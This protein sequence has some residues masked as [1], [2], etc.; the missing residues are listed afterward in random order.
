MEKRLEKRIEKGLERL[1]KS[2]W[3]YLVNDLEIKWQ[4][5]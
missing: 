3:T 2:T 5:D 4:K 1:E